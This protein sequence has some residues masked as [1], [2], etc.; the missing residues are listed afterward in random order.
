M[1]KIILILFIGLFAGCATFPERLQ[2]TGD[3]RDDFSKS[4]LGGMYFIRFKKLDEGRYQIWASVQTS[5]SSE[6]FSDIRSEIDKRAKEVAS[7]SNYKFE[8][9]KESESKSEGP[10]R[11]PLYGMPGTITPLVE[12]IMIIE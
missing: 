5:P 1:K 8:K 12:A 10:Y 7:G 4:L 9:Y 2:K 3:A 6:I 11:G